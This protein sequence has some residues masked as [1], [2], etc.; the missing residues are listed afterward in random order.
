MSDP[1]VDE[2]DDAEGPPRCTFLTL[3]ETKQ[4]ILDWVEA[5]RRW[6][7]EHPQEQ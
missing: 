5:K 7:A 1:N 4:L 2:G 6:Y 3:K